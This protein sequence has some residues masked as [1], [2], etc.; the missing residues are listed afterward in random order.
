VAEEHD[1]QKINL[2]NIAGLALDRT[3][4]GRLEWQATEPGGRRWVG[5]ITM[6]T[7]T[8]AGGDGFEFVLQQADDE[9]VWASIVSWEHVFHELW[10]ATGGGTPPVEAA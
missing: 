10:T 1:L 7:I 3:N 8:K 9:T 2:R 4:A 6:L 5:A